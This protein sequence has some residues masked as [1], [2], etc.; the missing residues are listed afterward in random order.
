MK[1][2]ISILLLLSLSLTF[3]PKYSL[4]NDNEITNESLYDILISNNEIKAK[5]EYPS[6]IA[7][8]KTSKSKLLPNHTPVVIRNDENIDTKNI[9]NGSKISF[10]IVNDV[11]DKN[12]NILIKSSTPVDANI[13]IQKRN[14]VGRS[15]E[16]TISDFH[17]KA[18]DGSYVPLSSSIA[19]NPDDKMV[20]SIVLSILVCPLF[21]LMK[22]KDAKLPEGTVKTVYTSADVYVDV[23]LL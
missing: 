10:T 9:I 2:L 16:I 21:L 11:K 23:N 4:A 1:K 3:L 18:I 8:A 22:G 19:V 6:M 13:F 17:T 15:A 5:F 12:G 14:Y 7:A 20:L